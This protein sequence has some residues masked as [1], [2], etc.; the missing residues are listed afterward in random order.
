MPLLSR[1]SGR[2][3]S[4]VNNKPHATQDDHAD[5]LPTPPAS[6]STR[7]SYSLTKVEDDEDINRDPES[8]EDEVSRQHAPA[9]RTTA[10]GFKLPQTDGPSETRSTSGFKLPKVASPEST[11]SKRG[12]DS[13]H[14][15]SDDNMLFS[16]QT[17]FKRQKS[18]TGNLH[19]PQRPTSK[20][21]TYGSQRKISTSKK[22]AGFKHAKPVEGRPQHSKATGAT[23]KAA[24]GADVF[25]FG[26]DGAASSFKNT[27]QPRDARSGA[28][29][30]AEGF[31]SLSPSL[32]SLSSPPSSPG[33]Q[34]IESLDLPPPKEYVA[35]TN[36]DIC[37]DEIELFL[38]QDFED[39]YVRGKALSYK[40]QQ[41]FCRYHKA[42][43]AKQLWK[44]RGYPDIQWDDL[45]KRFRR[46][47][48]HLNAV[49]ERKVPS[50]YREQLEDRVNSRSKTAAQA[51]DAG[52]GKRGASVGY[53]G[54]RGEKAMTEHVLSAFSDRLRDMAK[55]DR[56]IAAHGVSG[57]VSGYVQAVLVPELALRLVKEDLRVDSAEALNVVTESADL[58]ELLSNA[59]DD[60]ARRKEPEDEDMDEDL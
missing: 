31:N 47:H 56:L 33:V 59:V 53:Y 4:R 58:G 7:S 5:L 30:D 9:E 48:Q 37:G 11:S 43:K 55:R 38:K 25:E 45:P 34:V 39:Q 52:N 54:P 8:S 10:S 3:L 44:E 27:R 6:T 18:Y 17:S 57:G 14:A 29:P 46:H 35:K 1:Q 13:D 60:K 32:S 49:L 36:C 41:R 40:W 12:V 15:S 23:F 19:A 20:Q 16:S 42:H 2:L 24:K 26:K 50:N 51:L 21:K 22:S 28:E